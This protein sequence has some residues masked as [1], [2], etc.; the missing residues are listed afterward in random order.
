MKTTIELGEEEVQVTVDYNITPPEKEVSFLSNGD[1]GH[2]G[3][4][5]EVEILSVTDETGADY[6]GV[7]TEKVVSA[8]E[9]EVLRYN[10]QMHDY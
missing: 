6:L 10:E 7:L 2:Q 4:A 9:K 1:Y 5:V 8:L 3:S